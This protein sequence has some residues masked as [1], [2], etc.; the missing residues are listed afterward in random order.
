[1]KGIS[2]RCL[3]CPPSSCIHK[4]EDI[5][6]RGFP[7]QAACLAPEKAQA[8]SSCDSNPGSSV[9]AR[10]ACIPLKALESLTNSKIG[11]LR[12]FQTE[13]SLLFTGHQAAAQDRK[14]GGAW[15]PRWVSALRPGGCTQ[16][17]GGAAWPRKGSSTLQM[18]KL[19]LSAA[20]ELVG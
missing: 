11:C 12:C 3:C 15:W 7:I 5:P 8:S 14:E 19:S 18:G 1:M 17:R 16:A 9:R 13:G 2:C 20:L 6:L 4:D 10:Q